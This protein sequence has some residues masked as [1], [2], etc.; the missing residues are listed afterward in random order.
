MIHAAIVRVIILGG[1]LKKPNVRVDTHNQWAPQQESEF[2]RLL[3]DETLGR[4]CT[5]E[6]H[7]S[8]WE[9][10]KV[11]KQADRNAM[12]KVPQRQRIAVLQK[13]DQAPLPRTS[14][15]ECQVPEYAVRT[16]VRCR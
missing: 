15:G 13:H 1:E 16:A 10:V 8:I 5:K 14:R 6:Q 7:T 3:I 9:N 11:E 12:L 2:L 4:L